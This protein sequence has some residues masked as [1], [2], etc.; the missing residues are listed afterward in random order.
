L[1][2]NKRPD[3]RE[4]QFRV[5]S[6]PLERAG[7]ARQTRARLVFSVLDAAHQATT[8]GLAMLAFRVCGPFPYDSAPVLRN[9]YIRASQEDPGMDEG[10][11]HPRR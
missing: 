5:L 3:R 11:A 4:D 10:L 7:Q 2:V 9:G 8:M 6:G 1:R